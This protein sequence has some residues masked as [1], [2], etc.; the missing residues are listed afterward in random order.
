M[1][2]IRLQRI[3]K[4]NKPSYRVVISD[5]KRDLRGRHNEILGSY[6][7]VSQPKKINLKAER[8]KYWLSVGAKPSPTVHNLLVSQNIITTK[9]IKA[10]VPKKKENKESAEQAQKP[11]TAA[12]TSKQ[13]QENKNHQPDE[14][15]NAK[16]APG[17]QIG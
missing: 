6:D 17:E 13:E 7:P 2:A 1:L 10:W 9:K 14:T 3:G 11:E 5:K 12:H 16:E 4:K 8:I 15:K